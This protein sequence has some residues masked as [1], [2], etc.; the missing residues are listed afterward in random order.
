MFASHQGFPHWSQ[1]AHDTL[2]LVL[3]A[4]DQF[5]FRKIDLQLGNHFRHQHW[6]NP[7]NKNY[8]TLSSISQAVGNM[9]YCCSDLAKSLYEERS[10]TS[11]VGRA[12]Y[13]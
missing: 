3:G 1:D 5:R 12:T 9:L 7:G 11:P 13:A 4:R 10:M 8:G 6:V 2:G